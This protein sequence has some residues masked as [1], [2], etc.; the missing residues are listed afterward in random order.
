MSQSYPKRS[1]SSINRE[2]LSHSF[3]SR[4]PT[5]KGG[6]HL[7]PERVTN[8]THEGRSPTQKGVVHLLCGI[9]V[10]WEHMS[11]S[12]TQKG[13]VHLFQQTKQE[14]VQRVAVLPKKKKA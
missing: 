3:T 14:H 13:V 8:P 1:G 2:L 5:Q 10:L 7:S 12:P 11:R 4:S 9:P 6:V